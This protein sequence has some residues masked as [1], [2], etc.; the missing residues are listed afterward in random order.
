MIK[1]ILLVDDDEDELDIFAQ[2]LEIL[3]YPCKCTFFTNPLNALKSLTNWNPD[4]IFIDFRMPQMNGLRLLAEMRKKS[5][6]ENVPVVLY[7]SVDSKMIEEEAKDLGIAGIV[8]KT[9]SAKKLSELLKHLFIS[10]EVKA[11]ISKE[12]GPIS[13]EESWGTAGR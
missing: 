12:P 6:L 13:D 3:Q 5:T 2:A 7:S 8:E 1:Q 9:S 10:Q 11:L 4:F